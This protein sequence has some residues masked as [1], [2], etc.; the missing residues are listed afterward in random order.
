[1]AK[2]AMFLSHFPKIG[3]LPSTNKYYTMHRFKNLHTKQ[4]TPH[5]QPI[6]FHVNT[7]F[8]SIVCCSLAIQFS[9]LGSYPP[10]K[11]YPPA[12]PRL[13]L[14]AD[15]FSLFFFA[16]EFP[17]HGYYPNK[18][19]RIKIIIIFIIDTAGPFYVLMNNNKYS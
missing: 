19:L 9:T 7:N 13:K 17:I 16:T 2:K 5:I 11:L 14:S 8:F 15:C 3:F 18:Y 10:I 4:K 6:H 12:R 1:M